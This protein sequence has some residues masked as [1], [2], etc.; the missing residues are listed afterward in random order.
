[1]PI[2]VLMLNWITEII[3]AIS[4]SLVNKMRIQ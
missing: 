3:L 1:M 2:N 4:L